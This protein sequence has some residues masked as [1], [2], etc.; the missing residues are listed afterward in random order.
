MNNNKD[1]WF[2]LLMNDSN[3]LKRYEQKGGI[4]YLWVLMHFYY[5]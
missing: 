1:A 2:E 5:V 4:D 3:Y